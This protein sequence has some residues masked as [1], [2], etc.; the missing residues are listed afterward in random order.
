MDDCLQMLFISLWESD[1][2]EHLCSMHTQVANRLSGVQ[3]A[4]MIQVPLVTI[5]HFGQ[6]TWSS[7]QS[8][9]NT[10]CF[11]NFT[12][13]GKIN[14]DFVTVV[15]SV[16]QATS[17]IVVLAGGFAVSRQTRDTVEEAFLR[18]SLRDRPPWWGLGT[19]LCDWRVQR[20]VRIVCLSFASLQGHN[21]DIFECSEQAAV[22]PSRQTFFWCYRHDL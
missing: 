14:I 4:T 12:F 16:N 19:T 1:V 3:Q 8:H 10:T 20:A 22:A 7:P 5:E 15:T 6:A 9:K 21:T 13:G 2:W 11:Y 18:K 17:T